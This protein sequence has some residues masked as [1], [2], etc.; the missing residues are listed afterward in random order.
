MKVAVVV[1][2]RS[3]DEKVVQTAG[4]YVVYVREPPVGNRANDAVVR[5]LA[6]HLGVSRAQVRVV[7]G[8]RGRRKLVEIGLKISR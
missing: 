3:R 7:G 8:W 6:A 5:V 2:P 4:G 1:K